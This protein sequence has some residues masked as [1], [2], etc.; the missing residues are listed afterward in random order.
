MPIGISLALVAVF[1][2]DERFFRHRRIRDG[3]RASFAD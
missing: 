2:G 3:S 1:L